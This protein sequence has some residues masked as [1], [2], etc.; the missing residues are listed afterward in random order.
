MRRET[1]LRE[2]ADMYWTRPE[3]ELI[4]EVVTVTIQI[5]VPVYLRDEHEDP[6]IAVEKE[7]NEMDIDIVRWTVDDVTCDWGDDDWEGDDF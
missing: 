4:R 6:L 5:R 7:L 1:P 2:V 3:D